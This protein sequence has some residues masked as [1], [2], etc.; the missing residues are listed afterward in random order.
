M[1]CELR[2]P[3]CGGTPTFKLYPIRPQGLGWLPHWRSRDCGS[4]VCALINYLGYPI[5]RTIC[6]EMVA[7]EK[8]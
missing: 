8:E 3:R 1:R 2:C 4:L 6:L 7:A 5:K